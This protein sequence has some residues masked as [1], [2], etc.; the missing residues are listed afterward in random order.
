M[1]TKI[2]FGRF[3][4]DVDRGT[5]VC[6]GRP[7]ALSSKGIQLLLTLLRVPGQVISKAD[8]MRAAWSDTAVE[9]SNLSVQMA[10]LRKQWGRRLMDGLDSNDPACRISVH[11]QR[12]YTASYRWRQCA[13]DRGRAA[14]IDRRVAVHKSGW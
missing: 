10:A 12:F 3:V 1:A 8:L 7:I 2:A 14:P 5:L 4:L 6:E 11:R 9:E 13:E